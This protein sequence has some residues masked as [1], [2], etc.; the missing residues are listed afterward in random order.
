MEGGDNGRVIEEPYHDGEE[1]GVGEDRS[2][3]QRALPAAQDSQNDA[4]HRVEPSGLGH[5][6]ANE[7][8]D[9]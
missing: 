5:D 7:W 9:E 3:S 1:S 4:P 2:S 6:E 8:R